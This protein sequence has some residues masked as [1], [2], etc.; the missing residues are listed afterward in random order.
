VAKAL[1]SKAIIFNFNQ[2]AVGASSEKKGAK[3]RVLFLYLPS[4]E[5]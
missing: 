3:E 2:Y 1:H 4:M 5:K